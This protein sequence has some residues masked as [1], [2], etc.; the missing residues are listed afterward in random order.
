MHRAYLWHLGRV[1]QIKIDNVGR[2]SNGIDWENC[3]DVGPSQHNVPVWE[4]TNLVGENLQKRGYIRMI[5]MRVETDSWARTLSLLDRKAKT[6]W[7][8]NTWHDSFGPEDRKDHEDNTFERDP[9]DAS[10]CAVGGDRGLSAG[11]QEVTPKTEVPE[12]K[13]PM[14]VIASNCQI[15]TQLQ[16]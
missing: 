8:E 3:Y 9:R 15:R 2:R 16:Y 4:E 13:S 6:G 14:D 5:L 7:D 11:D 12:E 10:L 1:R